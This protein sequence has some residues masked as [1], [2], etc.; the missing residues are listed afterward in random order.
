VKECNIDNRLIGIIKELYAD[1]RICIK[2]ENRLSQPSMSF[3]RPMTGLQIVF[4][5]RH[6]AGKSAEKMAEKLW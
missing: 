6:L 1:N 4:T 5:V 3:E 2:Q